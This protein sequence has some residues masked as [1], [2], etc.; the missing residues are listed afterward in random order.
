M[1]RSGEGLLNAAL[2]GATLLALFMIL[3]LGARVLVHLD[4]RKNLGAAMQRDWPAP[5]DAPAKMVEMIRLSAEPTV[6]YELKPRLSVWFKDQRVTTSREGFRDTDYKTGKPADTVRIVGLGDSIMF[7]WGVAQDET[8][9]SLL[10]T[11]LNQRHPE[12][13]WEVLNTAVP[14]YNTVMEVAMLRHKGLRYQPDFVILGFSGNDMNL[15]RFIRDERDVLDP[16]SSFLIDF[17]R[18]RLGRLSEPWVP[19]SLKEV[20]LVFAP[21]R[22]GGDR[23]ENDPDRLPP[24]YRDHVGWEAYERALSELEDL[25]REHGFGVIQV[26]FRPHP[27]PL[28]DRVIEASSNRGFAV[29]D[30]GQAE[31]RYLNSRGIPLSEYPGSTLTR[32]EE[33][34]H[35]S[36]VSHRLC[37]EELLRHIEQGDNVRD[38]SVT[39]VGDEVGSTPLPRGLAAL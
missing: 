20:G 28:K 38:G 24:A 29:V 18:R 15:P 35:P 21:R 33:D 17:V 30:V 32:S 23:I 6:I 22:P 27:S 12:R 9:F 31:A 25:S 39:M 11:G 19:K 1:R 13:H 16:K 7:G 3:E 2:F 14:G 37:S 10:E 34:P 36:A 26:F 4:N 8:C 5:V